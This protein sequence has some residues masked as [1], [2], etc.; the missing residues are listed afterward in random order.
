V[1]IAVLQ[2]DEKA[3]SDS[4]Y[5]LVRSLSSGEYHTLT[6]GTL[7]A[8][9]GLTPL[10]RVCEISNRRFGYTDAWKRVLFCF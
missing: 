4:R 6:R 3:G 9:C 8:H 1:S 7:K 2:F 5:A 10:A